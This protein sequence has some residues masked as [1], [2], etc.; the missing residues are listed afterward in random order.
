MPDSRLFRRIFIISLSIGLF[1]FLQSGI[2][3]AANGST[4]NDEGMEV[5][6]RG[7]IHE[8]FADVNVD[9]T[10]P[11]IIATR[12]VPDPINEIPPDYR[13]EGDNVEWI[14]GY[15]SWD[16][17]QNDFIWVSGIW[18]DVPPG[19]EWIPGYWMSVDGGNQYVSGFWTD[20]NQPE[21]EYL[22]PPPKPLQAGPSSPS[23]SPYHVWTAG[24]WVWLH[25]RYAWQAGYWLQERPNMVWIPAHYVWSPRGYI[26][27][28]GYWDYQLDRRG[29]MFAPR[30]YAQPIY[31]AH[32]YYYTPSIVINIDTIF[33]SLFIRSDSHHYY[34]GDY[35]DD[36]Y[37]KRGFHPWYSEHATRYGYD[38]YYRSYRQLKLRNDKQW[39]RKYHQQF[40]Y[41][42]DHKEARPPVVY[43]QQANHKLNSSH[44]AANQ[45]IGRSLTD[46]VNDRNQPVRFTRLSSD[47]RRSVQ[48]Q[49][50]KR[51]TFQEKRREL[52]RVP[53]QKSRSWNTTESKK[54]LQPTRSA[55]PVRVEPN[56]TA[57]PQ[58]PQ[59][60]AYDTRQNEPQS[61]PKVQTQ[62]KPQSSQFQK[63][64]EQ[65]KPT[66]VRL[67]ANPQNKQHRRPEGFKL[68][69]Q[70]QPQKTK[71]EKPQQRPEVQLQAK[72]Q[73]K[74]HK[75]E[76]EK[77]EI[78]PEHQSQGRQ[79]QKTQ[80]QTNQQ[81]RTE[82]DGKHRR[83]QQEES[84]R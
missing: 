13:P 29:I 42:N 78:Q 31:R 1:F 7:P 71:Y 10:Q 21:T 23:F 47:Y 26:F 79:Y 27:V 41:R 8:A 33:L 70:N 2:A 37:E 17:D 28:V 82:Q 24:H 68:Q 61:Q 6:T 44:G 67:Q 52:E 76:Q 64:E 49:D 16:E 75:K 58:R 83:R 56:K 80:N 81:P 22:P 45:M 62:M 77:T 11:G 12:P 4:P 30:Y 63:R 69:P 65:Q 73:N 72:Q 57:M 48:T 35:F 25:D 40:Q 46:V 39:E 20:T 5:L 3:L 53:E 9:E 50:T 55:L 66:E 54:H 59:G 43:R 15:W 32:G 18:R 34:F 19:R 60:K 36:R 84:G 74:Q 38:P 14:P 51:N